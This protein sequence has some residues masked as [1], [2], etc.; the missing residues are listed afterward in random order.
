MKWPLTIASL[1]RVLQAL[2]VKIRLASSDAIHSQR[3]TVREIYHDVHTL[4]SVLIAGSFTAPHVLSL[5]ELLH[6]TVSHME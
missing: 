4:G 2:L 6:L 1:L 5:H 3:M